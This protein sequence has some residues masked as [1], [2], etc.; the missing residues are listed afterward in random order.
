MRA[1]FGRSVGGEGFT[2][3][4]LEAVID[5][6]CGCRLDQMFALQVRGSALID[7]APVVERLGLKLGIDTVPAVDSAGAPLPDLRLGMDFTRPG[8]PLRIV[9]RNPASAWSEAGVRTGDELIAI[10]GR[11]VTSF[12]GLRPALGALRLRG[13][14]RGEVGGR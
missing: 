8:P 5:S 2:S 11:A 9:I 14:T 12:C 10:G 7:L 13:T 3:A 1:L 4:T 6:L